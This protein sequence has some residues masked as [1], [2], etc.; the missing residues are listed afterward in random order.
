MTSTSWKAH[1]KPARHIDLPYNDP[2]ARDTWQTAEFARERVPEILGRARSNS[3]V[4]MRN[5]AE[6]VEAYGFGNAAKIVEPVEGVVRSRGW[7]PRYEL[8]PDS[9]SPLKL[10]AVRPTR[11]MGDRAGGESQGSVET[12]D[13][14]RQVMEVLWQL[15]NLA[16]HGPERVWHRSVLRS[17]SVGL[18]VQSIGLADAGP[19]MQRFEE[20]LA[21]QGWE[22]SYSFSNRAAGGPVLAWL[23]EQSSAKSS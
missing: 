22:V 2:Y 19:I 20:G 6:V 4:L 15:G 17:E 8:S 1:F 16:E 23:A 21:R 11:E 5:V 12:E 10:T 3:V 18:L 13:K 14:F 7:I 9:Q